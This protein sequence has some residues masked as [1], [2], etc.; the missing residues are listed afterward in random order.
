MQRSEGQNYLYI[1]FSLRRTSTAAQAKYQQ[2]SGMWNT[3]R[4]LDFEDM[5]QKPL[6][7]W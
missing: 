2:T 7:R 4:I 3:G 1:T 5:P 6:V